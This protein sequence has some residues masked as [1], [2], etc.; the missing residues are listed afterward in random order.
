MVNVAISAR[1]QRY[2]AGPAARQ[3]AHRIFKLAVQ[4]L[5]PVPR[6][7]SEVLSLQ[8]S[9]HLVLVAAGLQARQA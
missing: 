6:Q 4:L 7:G 9:F 3:P 1:H 8:V 5:S 2:L